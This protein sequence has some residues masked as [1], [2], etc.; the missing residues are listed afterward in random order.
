MIYEI[1]LLDDEQLEYINTYFNHLQFEDGRS[2]NLG[3]TI[4]KVCNSAYNGPGYKELNYYCLQLICAKMSTYYIKHPSQIYFSEYPTGGVYS[5]HVDNNPIGGVNAHYSMTCFL[6]D[7]YEGG[8][9]VIQIGDTEVPVKYKAG[10]A[11]L[12]PPNLVHRVNEITSGSRKVFCCWMQ[13]I[14]EDSFT[15]DWIVDYGRYLDSLHD[16]VPV[17]VL[18][19]LDRF[20]MNLVR[21]HGNFF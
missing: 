15:R 9:L 16:R 7:D 2:S 18:G 8:E 20:R 11:V 3:K 19:R 5:N 10:K 13:S 17:D 1:D 12:Y 6:N 14:I 21:E 4:N